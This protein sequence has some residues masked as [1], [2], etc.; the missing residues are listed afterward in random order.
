M[1]VDVGGNESRGS[2][3]AKINRIRVENKFRPLRFRLFGGVAE[4]RPAM[5]II[6]GF[7]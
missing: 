4:L 5:E 2:T 1:K 6:G 7:V 3:I